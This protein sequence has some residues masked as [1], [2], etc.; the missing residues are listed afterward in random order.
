[1]FTAAR[2]RQGH[3]P[4]S[5]TPSG[6][7]P[8]VQICYATKVTRM[9]HSLQLGNPIHGFPGASGPA[10]ARTRRSALSINRFH[11]DVREGAHVSAAVEDA[12]VVI[13]QLRDHPAHDMWFDGR[14]APAPVAPK[15]TLNVFDLNRQASATL[16]H[17]VDSLILHLPRAALDDIAED[18]GAP[19]IPRLS[20]PVGW[21]TTDATLQEMQ[22]LLLSALSGPDGSRSLFADHMILAAGAHIAQ[23]YGEMKPRQQRHGTL[24]LWQERRAKELIAANLAKQVSL[25]EI[26]EECDLSLAYFSRAFKASTGSTPH[27]WLEM[28]RIDFARDLL[29]S[30]AS[31]AEIAIT[32][33][34]ADQSHLT[35]IFK[36]MTGTT[37]AA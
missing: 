4:P 34:F 26:A 25:A 13:F 22:G 1:M 35:R 37:P 27:R 20:A 9:V 17:P 14:H 28:R 12:Y 36:R 33:G 3:R 15:G 21:A 30:G 11:G 31:V 19:A 32:S 29:K 10:V 18:A 23:T 5:I 16:K 6:V 2:Y 8:D 7:S 24:A